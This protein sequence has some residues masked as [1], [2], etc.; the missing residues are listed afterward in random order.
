MNS[1]V[2]NVAD[3]CMLKSLNIKVSIKF[4][5]VDLERPSLSQYLNLVVPC[6]SFNWSEVILIK[7]RRLPIGSAGSYNDQNRKVCSVQNRNPF[8]LRLSSSYRVQQLNEW[9]CRK[10]ARI[11]QCTV[12]LHRAYS[13]VRLF[14]ANLV[15]L[16]LGQNS[17]SDIGSLL[18]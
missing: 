14:S 11:I 12:F 8:W 4:L 10:A 13:L 1:L 9:S 15:F 7:I 3:D 17:L 16:R 6:I 18:Y 5:D 2:L